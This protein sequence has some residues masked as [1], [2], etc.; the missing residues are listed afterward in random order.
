[1]KTA[2]T[3]I[4]RLFLLMAGAVMIIFS[5]SG[6]A[7]IP[8]GYYILAQVDPA[9]PEARTTYEWPCGNILRL[10]TIAIQEILTEPDDE[11][12]PPDLD[13]GL[14]IFCIAQAYPVSLV[15]D[16]VFWPYELWRYYHRPPLT[17]EEIKKRDAV[18][19]NIDMPR[20]I[21]RNEPFSVKI[22]FAGKLDGKNLVYRRNGQ[23]FKVVFVAPIPHR[24]EAVAV[25][26]GEPQTEEAVAPGK[27]YEE[28]FKVDAPPLHSGRRYTVEIYFMPD[29]KISNLHED[30]RPR[31]MQVRLIDAPKANGKKEASK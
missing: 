17:E 12:L 20:E 29:E 5:V 2:S 18:V 11:V 16:V 30:H 31:W 26:N 24:H 1:M 25:L 8:T 13:R 19:L 28:S 15:Y 4:K 10:N 21:R 9:L 3:K 6:C 14:K 7:V 27:I 23:N 22:S